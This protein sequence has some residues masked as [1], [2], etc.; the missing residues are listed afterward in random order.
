[1]EGVGG[2]EQN[3]GE[4]SLVLHKSFSTLCS[5]LSNER[6]TGKLPRHVIVLLE[7]AAVVGCTLQINGKEIN[8]LNINRPVLKSIFSNDKRILINYF[9]EFSDNCNFFFFSFGLLFSKLLL[10][11]LR[12]SG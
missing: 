9:R 8:V 1:M 5:L 4:K 12:M 6:M 11:F 7:A 10:F 3:Y 2:G